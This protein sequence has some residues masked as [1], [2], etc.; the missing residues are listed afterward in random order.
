MKRI[1]LLTTLFFMSLLFEINAQV[2][3][4]YGWEPTSPS[5][6]GWSTSGASG[7]R[8]TGSTVCSGSASV[9]A[10]LY[11]SFPSWTFTS[12]SLGTSQGGLTTMTFNYKVANWSANTTGTP[13]TSFSINVQWATSSAGPWNSL[14]EINSSNHVVA[15]TCAA[16]PGTYTFTPNSGDNV[17][18]RFVGARTAGDFY[19]NFDDVVVNEALPPCALPTPGNTIA[20]ATAVC[21]GVSFNLSLQNATPG[22]GVSYQWQSSPDNSTWTNIG[23]A[24]S[25]TLSTSQTADT[26][27]RC[28][29]T[30]SGEGTTPSNAVQVTMDAPANCYCTGTHA[31]GGASD[32]IAGVVLGSLS[33]TGTANNNYTYY[34]ALTVPDLIQGAT[35]TVAVTFG[36]DGTQYYAV[37]IDWNQDGDFYDTNETI[38]QVTSGNQAGGSA[39]RNI[40]IPVPV[41]ATLGQTRMRVRGGDDSPITDPCVFTNSSYGETEDYRVNVIAPV[42]CTGTPEAGTISGTLIRETCIG[43]APSPATITAT[44]ADNA[45]IDVLYQWE[46]SID[47]GSSWGNVTGGSGATSAIYTPPVYAGTPIQYRLKVTCTASGLFDVS[48]VVAEITNKTPPTVQASAITTSSVGFTTATVTWASGNGGR[49][50]VVINTTNSFTNPTGTGDVTVAG[51]VYTGSGEQIV[52]DGTGS[53]VS[54]SGLSNTTTYYVRVYE[55][56]RCAGT[57]NYNYYQVSTAT[58]NPGTFTTL[59]PPDCPGDLGVGTVTISSLPYIATGQTN[60]GNGNNLTSANATVC[61]SGNYYG[62]EDKTYIFTAPTSGGYTISLS[63]SSSYTG[64]MLYE[65]C[66]FAGRGGT[67]VTFSQSSGGNKTLTPTLTAGLTYYLV[68]DSWPSPSCHPSYNISIIPPITCPATSTPTVSAVTGTDATLS[69]TENGSATHWDIYYATTNTPPVLATIPIINDHTPGTTYTLTNLMGSTTYY[70]WVR[71][72]CAM[73]NTDVSTWAGPVIFTTSCALPAP[74]NTIAST[75]T[76]CSG[77]SFN[78]SLQ[79]ATPGTGVSYQWQSSPDNSTWTN[80][81]SATSATLSTS[82][83]AATYYRC[84][85]TCSG[86]GT[87]PSNAVQVTMDTPTNCYCTVSYTSGVEPITLVNFANIN[88]SSSA[89]LGSGGSLE[90]YTAIVGTVYQNSSYTIRLKGN[91]DGS[92]T[93]YFRVFIDFNQDGIW[94]AGE[95]F[96]CGTIVSSTGVDAKETTAIIAIPAT[97]LTGNTRMRVTKLYNAYQTT[98]CS[99]GSYGQSE[100]YTLDINELACGE[101]S[102]YL[103]TANGTYTLDDPCDDGNGWTY[104]SDPNQAGNYMF[105]IQW[106]PNNTGANV[107]AKANATVSVNVQ[108]MISATNGSISASYGMGRYWNVN[109]N[110]SSMNGL[111]NVKFFYDPLE[112]T[113]VETASAAFSTTNGVPNNGFSWFKTQSTAFTPGDI[114]AGD[115]QSSMVL[116]T[117]DGSGVENG[118]TYVQSNDISSFSGGTGATGAGAGFLPVELMAFRGNVM[119]AGNKLSW[120][121]ATEQNAARFVI[122]RSA[123]GH[124]RWLDLGSVAATGNAQVTQQYSFMDDKPLVSAYYRLRMIDQDNSFSYS[125]I[126]Q[127]QRSNKDAT[128]TVFPVPAQDEIQVSFFLTQ[129]GPVTLSLFDLTGKLVSKTSSNFTVGQQKERLDVSTLASG[130]YLLNVEIDGQ[131]YVERVIKQ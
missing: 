1:L 45:T 49:R 37:Y 90:D 83:T 13:A 52:Y 76:V 23:S 99:G 14:G 35:A 118:V 47:S 9:R 105:A 55:Y 123:D 57:P 26:Y 117:E 100:D 84:N 122:E 7:A 34:S 50:Y 11:G 63:T 20:S 69:W 114:T 73:D 79:N 112:K 121:T 88:N 78:L 31:T 92:F 61:G 109:L 70:A 127:L 12:P 98:A 81:G 111:V 128:I 42:A 74:G 113:A 66:P 2:S 36:S 18:V 44:G 91:T 46:E 28:N 10:N 64:L 32:N 110:G 108:G 102:V 53:S 85:V 38:V 119:D 80:I 29:V 68:V 60:C 72:D 62:G 21:S 4:N 65:G 97:A 59:T 15:G 101:N 124:A 103:E 8:F 82:Q 43:A 54:I 24:T 71:A 40:S 94:G 130:V 106:D 33:N 96:N 30:C 39:T 129:T 17:F 125:P 86:E 95:S 48:D 93:N 120:E 56:T 115:F 25:A 107:A 16:G 6:G 104:Y 126:I 67:C 58:N 77:V 131:R 51:T 75:T 19:M 3:Y 27:Y 5:L 22:T 116:L 41:G 87:T 89:A